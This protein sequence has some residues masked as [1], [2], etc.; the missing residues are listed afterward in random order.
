MNGDDVDDFDL[1][2]YSRDFSTPPELLATTHDC[3]GY[4]QGLP[5]HRLK[6]T[7]SQDEYRLKYGSWVDGNVN[8]T[9][10]PLHR[11]RQLFLQVLE[12]FLCRC[13]C[14]RLYRP[15]IPRSH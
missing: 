10:V 3:L 8:D 13:Y 4:N 5:T 12:A 7:T 11:R 1:P 2:G 6:H 15:G 14:W 9:L